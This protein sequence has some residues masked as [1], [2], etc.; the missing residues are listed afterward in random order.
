MQMKYTISIYFMQCANKKVMQIEKS[1]CKLSLYDLMRIYII[2]FMIEIS[3]HMKMI[4]VIG[5]NL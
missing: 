2:I 4:G 1:A 3:T 5:V